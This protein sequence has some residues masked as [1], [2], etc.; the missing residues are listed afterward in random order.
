LVDRMIRLTEI[1]E[2]PCKEKTLV[3]SP[4]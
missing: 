2:T 1:S 3:C 4:R